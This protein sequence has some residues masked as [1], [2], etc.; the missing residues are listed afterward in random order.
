MS[1]R[2]RLPVLLLMTRTVACG[3]MMAILGDRSSWAA[4]DNAMQVVADAT[5]IDAE[6]RTTNTMFGLVFRYGEEH[7]IQTVDVMPLG[8]RRREFETALNQRPHCHAARRDMRIAA[9]ALLAGVPRLVS[10]T[11]TDR[12]FCRAFDGS[13]RDLPT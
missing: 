6:C 12:S 11:V 8:R 10:G 13:D 5:V 1:H 3:L 9:S 7:G 2:L 4:S